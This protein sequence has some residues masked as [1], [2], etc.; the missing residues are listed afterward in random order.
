MA[1]LK[2]VRAFVHDSLPPFTLIRGPIPIQA[3]ER[4]YGLSVQRRGSIDVS[5]ADVDPSLVRVGVC[6]GIESGLGM[7][8]WAGFVREE[9][10][11][12]GAASIHIPLDGPILGILDGVEISTL[13]P[14][15]NAIEVVL[16]DVFDQVAV[17]K[18]GVVLGSISS[19]VA[20]DIEASGDRASKVLDALRSRTSNDYREN[21]VQVDNTL[22][23]TVD[24]GALDFPT[25]KTLDQSVIVDGIFTR[26]RPPEGLTIV[27]TGKALS[28][29]VLGGRFVA[30][31]DIGPGSTGYAAL[32]D[33][34]VTV[35]DVPSQLVDKLRGADPVAL[36]L[37]LSNP[38]VQALRPGSIFRLVDREWAAGFAVDT[39]VVVRRIQPR[40][41]RGE[42]DVLTWV[43]HNE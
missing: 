32:V 1:V 26:S 19:A 12:R 16:R 24:F 37:D 22:Q 41:E 20:T 29:E 13:P 14:G 8:Y 10:W 9:S 27:G 15:P 33:E 36:V 39:E 25:G 6:W 43:V 4:T 3:Q 31:R 18:P 2:D 28:S 11:P 17:K 7:P 35:G 30:L 5:V 38:D 21:V 40:E 23:F 34:R 42:L